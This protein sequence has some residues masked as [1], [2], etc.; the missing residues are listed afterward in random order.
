MVFVVT[1]VTY[2][3]T[4]L[5]NKFISSVIPTYNLVMKYSKFGIVYIPTF[6]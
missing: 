1:V 2:V 5:I 6:L 3:M 4:L